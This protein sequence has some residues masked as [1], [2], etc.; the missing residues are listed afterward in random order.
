VRAFAHW[1]T[2]LA[3]ATTAMPAASAEPSREPAP[4]NAAATPATPPAQEVTPRILASEKVFYGW[5]ILAVGETG[6]LLAAASVELPSSRFGSQLATFAFLVGMP[7]YALGGPVTHWSHGSFQKGL[8]S[9]GVNATSV[10]VGGLIG[11]GVRCRPSDASGDCGTRGFFDGLALA[12]VTVPILDA[13]ILGWE[14][15]PL[16]YEITAS[17]RASP[18]VGL[19]VVSVGPRSATVCFSGHF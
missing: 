2:A 10:A 3:V 17:R 14:E 8:V 13:L 7:A 6:G 9:F 19:P 4:S 15:L 1:V 12:V 5:Q 16:G 11:S 18:S